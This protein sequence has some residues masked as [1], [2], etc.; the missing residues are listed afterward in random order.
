MGIQSRRRRISDDEP[1][2]PYERRTALPPADGAHS[3]RCV[4]RRVSGGKPDSVR[5][6][7]VRALWRQPRDRPPRHQ[8]IDGRGNPAQA[9]GQRHVRLHTQAM[10]RPAGHQQLPRV[11][12]DAGRYPRHAP[13]SRAAVPRG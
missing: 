1:A 6:G 3:R 4:Q 7:N 11:L 8:R 2:H 12:P 9:A 13:D 10:P 5:A